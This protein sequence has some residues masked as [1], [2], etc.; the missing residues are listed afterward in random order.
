MIRKLFTLISI[1]ML[2]F[3][4]VS[5]ND[6]GE[7]EDDFD[8]YPY[9]AE[10]FQRLEDYEEVSISPKTAKW[11]YADDETEE[12]SLLYLFVSF[13]RTGS[14]DTFYAMLTIY[15]NKPLEQEEATFID[16]IYLDE[17]GA[18]QSSA[19]GFQILYDNML[20]QVSENEQFLVQTG[21]ISKADIDQALVS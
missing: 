3:T 5:C 4:L 9:L 16:R 19:T 6:E 14:S 21:D 10:A 11:V 2:V 20:S 7:L 18:D 17:L 1:L 12:L 8:P 15:I 13:G